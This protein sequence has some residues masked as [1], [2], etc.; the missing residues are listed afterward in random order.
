MEEDICLQYLRSKSKIQ[1]QKDLPKIVSLLAQA[2]PD[3]NFNNCIWI[4]DSFSKKHFL[5]EDV[6]RVKD[7]LIK[8]QTL[9]GVRRH[10]PE[11]GYKELKKMN[12]EREEK[13][14]KKLTAKTTAKT[15]T[16]TIIT[17]DDCKSYFTWICNGNEPF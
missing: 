7:D 5:L 3:P 15:K 11:E 16:S 6:E 9:F 17:F 10:F 13:K 2:D 1:D 8:F 14:E 4:I 12:R